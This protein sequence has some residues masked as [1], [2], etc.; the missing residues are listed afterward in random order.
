MNDERNF[1]LIVISGTNASGKSSLGIDLAQKYNGEIIIAPLASTSGEGSAIVNFSQ[2]TKNNPKLTF[3]PA[4]EIP[5]FFDSD[6]FKGL[7]KDQ[8]RLYEEV[9]KPFD[10]YVRFD[11][12]GDKASKWMSP[13]DELGWYGFRGNATSIVFPYMAPNNNN[14]FYST[15]IAP[16]L[17]FNKSG[18]K[19]RWMLY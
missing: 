17:T 15:F 7:S 6:Y 1:P 13:N 10:N 16:L 4:D 12:S 5:L 14:A 8:Q 2:Y 19:N 3:M 11:P 18:V 9:I